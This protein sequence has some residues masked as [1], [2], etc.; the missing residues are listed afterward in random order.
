MLDDEHELLSSSELSSDPQ[1]VFNGEDRSSRDVESEA[2][3]TDHHSVAGEATLPPSDANEIQRTVQ[4]GDDDNHGLYE[5][6]ED[7]SRGLH[8][9]GQGDN[10]GLYEDGGDDSRGLHEDG[11]GDN[12]GLYEDGGDDNRS[13]YEDGGDAN[14]GLNEDDD[15]QNSTLFVSFSQ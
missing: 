10:R 8:E 14:R 13:L 11:Q 3:L 6:S 15:G 2:E 7:D 9:D 12:R 4:Y 1:D 5:D